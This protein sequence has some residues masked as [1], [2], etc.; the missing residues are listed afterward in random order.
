[1]SKKEERQAIVKQRWMGIAL[2]VISVLIIIVASTGTTVIDR[3]AGACMLTIPLGLYA[4]CTKNIII[5][6]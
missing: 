5:V 2:L 3:D 1:M 4:L 6:C